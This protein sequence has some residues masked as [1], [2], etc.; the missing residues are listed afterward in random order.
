ML[1]EAVGME[2]RWKPS[3]IFSAARI[4]TARLKVILFSSH[5]GDFNKNDRIYLIVGYPA[6]Q[7]QAYWEIQDRQKQKGVNTS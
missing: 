2:E 5:G 6:L 7:K 1:K 4:N 3:P